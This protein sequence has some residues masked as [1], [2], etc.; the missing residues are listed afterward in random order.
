MPLVW[1]AQSHVKLITIP[2][3]S[4][5]INQGGWADQRGR[6]RAPYS[7]SIQSAHHWCAQGAGTAESSH[8]PGRRRRACGL[9]EGLHIMKAAWQRKPQTPQRGT[10]GRG[11]ASRWRK[12]LCKAVRLQACAKSEL[13]PCTR[14]QALPTGA[15]NGKHFPT[16][17]IH[18]CSFQAHRNLKCAWVHTRAW[19]RPGGVALVGSLT[20]AGRGGRTL[21][22]PVCCQ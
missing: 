14:I 4:T 1:R 7:A 8:R 5:A 9:W 21:P 3:T 20:S 12:R 18:Q 10:L 15:P 22:L 6:G 17:V 11:F 13:G 2:S 19:G 16:G